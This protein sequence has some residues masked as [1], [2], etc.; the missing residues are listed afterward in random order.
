MIRERKF[1]AVV[2]ISMVVAITSASAEPRPIDASWHDFRF[3]KAADE[4]I[5]SSTFGA[6]QFSIKF[7]G[8]SVERDYLDPLDSR[9]TRSEFSL[10]PARFRKL[11]ATSRHE[12]S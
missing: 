6:N 2:F 3:E 4:G 10:K 9:L 1:L 8:A 12:Q 11:C 5:L 7:K